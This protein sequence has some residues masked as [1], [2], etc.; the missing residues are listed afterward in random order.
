MIFLV[1]SASALVFF[2]HTWTTGF[3]QITGN[4]GDTR[5]AIYLDEHWL[6]VFKGHS[7]WLNPAYFYPLKGVLGWTD[8]FLL[9][10]IFYAPLRELGADQF[11]SFELTLIA[12]S[13]VGFVGFV[14]L[15]KMLFH[16]PLSVALAGGWLFSFANNL[17]IHA[18]ETQLF[19][20]YFLPGITCLAVLAWRNLAARNRRSAVLFMILGVVYGLFL[21]SFYYVAW[22]SLLAAGVLF[23]VTAALSPGPMM[24][25]LAHKLKG[26]WL[27]LASGICAFGLAIIPFL[28]TY[29]PVIDEFGGRNFKNVLS[30]A[31]TLRDLLPANSNLLWGPILSDHPATYEASYAITPVLFLVVVVAGPFVLWRY[32]VGSSENRNGLTRTTIALCI[33]TL[34]LMVLP[35]KAG[36][37]SFWIIVWQFPGAKAIR[38]SDRLEVVTDL[39]A[40]LAFVAVATIVLE[41]AQTRRRSPEAQWRQALVVAIGLALAIVVC[42]E[43]LN[44]GPSANISR[45]QQLALLQAVPAP[46]R[47]CESFYLT[48]SVNRS[49]RPYV[50]QIDAMLISQKIGLP[51]LN[52]Y[53]GETPFK[54]RLTFPEPRYTFYA[55]RWAL[56]NHVP[57]S[58]ICEL[59]IGRMTWTTAL[60]SA[61][62]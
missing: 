34:I 38:A 54:W 32:R 24:R 5:L 21:F 28:R 56:Q 3:R 10:Q 8:T 16:V 40:S 51:T 1:W 44:T 12:A 29:V 52:G 37:S 39:V 43:Q 15:A 62:S 19:G 25:R 35:M 57:L 60:S 11:L 47:T 31:P 26:G 48:D 49:E 7:S 33:T 6:L 55:T 36:S 45:D 41:R 46:P 27:P 61:P 30:Y 9:D 2:R 18:S 53:S 23:I 14:L 50:Y 17:A 58:G 59:D 22:L 13:L 4:L 42:F 20:V